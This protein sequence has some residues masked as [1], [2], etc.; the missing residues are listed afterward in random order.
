MAKKAY[1]YSGTDWVPL[2]SE[3]TDLTAYSTSTEIANTYA[4]KADN[5]L[6]HINTTSFSAVASQSLND[7]FSATYDNY[8]IFINLDSVS[9]TG[10]LYAR[11]R[12]SGADNSSA[13]YGST[14]WYSNSSGG[15]GVVNNGTTNIGWSV[16]Y[17][18]STADNG[19]FIIDLSSP[20][21]A[22]LTMATSWALRNNDTPPTIGTTEQ[23]IQVLTHALSSSF[24][25]ITVYRGSGS[26]TGAI[27][28]FG[29]KK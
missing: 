9:A 23:R 27:S 7:I 20:F 29:V 17:M 15:S 26:M 10:D 24:D 8:K 14:G 18:N 19:Y 6:V 4:T 13:I 1:V 22:K 12:V 28:I 3:V 11:L 2:A 16:G 5:G 25:G 21:I